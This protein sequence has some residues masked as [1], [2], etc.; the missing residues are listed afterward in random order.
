M[1][2]LNKDDVSIKEANVAD[3]S[4]KV[5]TIDL[6]LQV[7]DLQTNKAVIT[8]DVSIVINDGHKDNYNKFSKIITVNV[9]WTCSQIMEY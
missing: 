1:K 5:D 3:S 2:D 8:C 7:N 9:F 4:H 6:T